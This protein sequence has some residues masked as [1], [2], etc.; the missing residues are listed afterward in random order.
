ME[1]ILDPI[2]RLEAKSEMLL[3]SYVDEKTCMDCKKV[4]D[5]EL[6]CPDPMGYG[7]LICIECLGF[8]PFDNLNSNRGSE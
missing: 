1:K 3:D 7:P 6:L 5:Y 8:D 2:E 4:V